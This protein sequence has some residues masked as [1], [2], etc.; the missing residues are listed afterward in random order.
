MT[1]TTETTETTEAP[2]FFGRIV[3][4]AKGKVQQ[5]DRFQQTHPRFAM[6]V[7][8]FK[9]FGEDQAG[10]LAALVSHYA[11][12]SLFPLLLVF[13]TVLQYVLAG[14]PELMQ[15]VLDSALG[16]F[17]V[18]GDQLR[19]I[20]TV[21][22]SGLALVI[23]IVGAL[24]GG[25]GA[26]ES[27]QNAMNTIWGVPFKARPSFVTSKL[28]SLAM[29]A[30]LGA[31]IIGSTVITGAAAGAEGLPVIGRLLVIP[32]TLALNTG[33]FLGSFKILT[34]ADVTWRELL[35]GA[36]VAGVAFAVLQVAGSWYVQHVLDGA[37]RIYG[38]FAIVLGL[39]SWLYLQAQLTIA[40]AEINVVRKYELYPRSI[41]GPELTQGDRRALRTY[42]KIEERHPDE[43]VEI[44]LSAAPVEPE[45]AE[46]TA[47][48]SPDAKTPAESEAILKS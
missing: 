43:E 2:G 12:F 19:D 20:G 14:N 10:N 45:S 42:A 17:P 11:F 44:D 25:L 9:K 30:F 47:P 24:W 15:K 34:Q 5:A 32:L 18:L 40:A 13:A 29:L 27:M 6:P 36:V 8:V 23:G 39:L 7:A 46:N 41:F 16:K 35:P 3:A 31:T 26:I 38:T 48:P 4:T 37:S 33:L 1:K 21:Q 22:G 28:R